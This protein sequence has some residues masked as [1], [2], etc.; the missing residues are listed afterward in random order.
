MAWLIETLLRYPRRSALVAGCLLIVGGGWAWWQFGWQN[1]QRVF[2]DMLVN[3]LA[4]P[5][6]TRLVAAAS[7]GQSID[8]AVRLDAGAGVTDW[9]V[10]ARQ[11]GSTVT[12]ESLGTH[13]TGYIRYTQIEGSTA[14]KAKAAAFRQVLNTWAKSD[15]K[16]DTQL[17]TLFDQT[18][19]DIT[20]APTPPIA[21]MPPDQ[22]SQLLQF[23]Q[24]ERVFTPDYAHARR[25]TVAGRP[26]YMYAVKLNLAAYVRLMQ[27]FARDLGL[28]S[29]DT[30]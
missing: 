25:T 16:T 19:L 26:A 15:G 28:N 18:L 2:L 7:G 8:Q 14:A 1:P 22:R 30:V 21:N 11:N 4:T 20:N 6:V 29:L 17:Q 3:N 13:S 27:S 24:D 12:T 23:M 9:L 5:S 10:T